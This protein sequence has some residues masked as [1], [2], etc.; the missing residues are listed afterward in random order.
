MSAED[1]PGRCPR[2]PESALPLCGPADLPG[3]P[4]VAVS[5][6]RH[7]KPGDQQGAP[8]PEEFPYYTRPSNPKEKFLKLIQHICKQSVFLHR[9]VHIRPSKHPLQGSLVL[10][11]SARV[12]SG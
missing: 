11:K 12:L 7:K 6:S 9:D 8:S 2:S 4:A 1:R 5:C 10:V 3:Q